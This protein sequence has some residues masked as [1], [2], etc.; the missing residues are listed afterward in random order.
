[1]L[2]ESFE[3][4]T[5]PPAGWTT[6]ASGGIMITRDTTTG[7]SGSASVKFN[8]NGANAQN[9][10]ISYTVTVT[11]NSFLSFYWKASSEPGGD[12]LSFCLDSTPCTINT[13]GITPWTKV[14]YNLSP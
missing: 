7:S 9:A 12:I 13:S 14:T 1:M 3:S 4:A 2:N 6:V 11:S 10:S 8:G 5:F